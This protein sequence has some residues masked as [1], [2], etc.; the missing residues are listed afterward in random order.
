[1]ENTASGE[2]TQEIHT[3]SGL[4]KGRKAVSRTSSSPPSES[5]T[6]IDSYSHHSDLDK[7]VVDPIVECSEGLGPG[8]QVRIPK[9]VLD[10]VVPDVANRHP[11]A[12]NTP[13][14]PKSTQSQS[15]LLVETG[16]GKVLRQAKN[17]KDE[18]SSSGHSVVGKDEG[19]FFRKKK[20]VLKSI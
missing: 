19:R 12:Q 14:V 20:M 5:W 9:E 6:P 18:T 17:P 15:K 8:S 10:V 4:P 1:M 13:G 3:C 16:S 11:G 2:K 7:S